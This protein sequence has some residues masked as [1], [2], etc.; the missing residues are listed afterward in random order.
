MPLDPKSAEQILNADLGNILKKVKAGKPLTSA[1]RERIASAG[2]GARPQIVDTMKQA[3]AVSGIPLRQLKVYKARGCAAFL[4]GSRVDVDALKTY[5]SEHA[6]EIKSEP[7]LTKEE[8]DIKLKEV[9]IARET[10]ALER[11]K[12]LVIRKAEVFETCKSASQHMRAVLQQKLETELPPKC[13][14]K[15]VIEIAQLMRDTVD[16]VCRIFHDRTEKWA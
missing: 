2:E 1:E 10:L 14:G 11:D 7:S 6:E 5:H 3:A 8:A 16:A 15:T 12:G 4:K 9:K 13:A